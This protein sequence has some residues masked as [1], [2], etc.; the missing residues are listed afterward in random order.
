MSVDKKHV[1]K[2]ALKA[3]IIDECDKDDDISLE[4]FTDDMEFFDPST[5]L[6]LDSLDA[7]QL[8]LAVQKRYGVRLEGASVV[9]KHMRT[10][11]TLADYI[12]QH[13]GA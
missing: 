7:L 11:Q 5:A 3:M 12:Y 2:Q 13:Q 1:L 9:R 4:E 8:S 6:A 10:V